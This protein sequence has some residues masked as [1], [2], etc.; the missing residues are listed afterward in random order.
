MSEADREARIEQLLLSGLD[1][2]FAGRYERAINIWTRVA[3][4]ERGHGRARAYIERARGALAERQRE[5]DELVYA[6]IAAYHAGEMQTARDL[7][8]RATDAGGSSDTAMLFIERI[9]RLDAAAHVRLP[10]ATEVAVPAQP[11]K[12]VAPS[13]YWR[14]LSTL[15]ASAAIAAVIVIGSLRVGAWVA[16]RP[17]APPGVPSVAAVEP[18][19]IVRASDM[20]MTR[21]RAL[22]AAG[23][24]AAALRVLESVDIGDPRRAA[25]DRLRAEIQ[26]AVLARERLARE[27]IDQGTQPR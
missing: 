6:G 21:A 16:E 22:A 13:N 24:A 1:Q 10:A 12:P 27:T 19:P 20:L 14:W 7:L 11:A 8:T 25:T 3:F 2:Y 4:L 26:R 9:Q 15:A 17:I 23:S 18:L 5:A